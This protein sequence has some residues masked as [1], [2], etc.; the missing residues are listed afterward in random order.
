LYF[1]FANLDHLFSFIVV[2]LCSLFIINLVLIDR[3]NF[4]SLIDINLYLPVIYLS[5]HL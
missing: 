4:A 2:W 5:L 1:R 3:F